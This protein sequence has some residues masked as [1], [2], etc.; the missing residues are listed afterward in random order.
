MVNLKWMS[1]V[2][3]TVSKELREG[4]GTGQKLINRSPI[5]LYRYTSRSIF[6]RAN[7]H[8]FCGQSAEFGPPPRIS[9]LLF[10]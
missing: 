3:S 9:V 5:A 10:I 4:L 7:I 1:A 6:R 2:K 8:S